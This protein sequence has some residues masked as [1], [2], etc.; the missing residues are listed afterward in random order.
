[1][2][3]D[4]LLE[5]GVEELP[6]RFVPSTVRQLK[7]AIEKE[8]EGGRLPFRAG[9]T[10]VFATPRRVAAIC[11]GL[12]D[13]QETVVREVTGPPARVAY[14][15][16][17][18]PT[19]AALGFAKSQGVDV[20]VLEVRDDYVRVEVT[21][22]GRQATEIL[23]D[24]LASALGSLSFPKTM[25]WGPDA[26]FGRPIRWIVAL[27][28]EE[29]LDLTYAG[30]SAGRETRGL[31]FWSR[32]PHEI[33]DPSEYVDVLERALVIPDVDARRGVIADALGRA[34][35][36]C[37]GRVVRDDELLEEVTF[38]VECP[39]VFA[40]RFDERFLELP[41]DVIVA[42]MKG[43]QRYFAVDSEEGTLLPR[44]LCVTNGPPDFVD[45]I[46]R[47]NERVLESRLDDAAFY[48]NED[49]KSPLEEKVERLRNVVWLEGLGTLFEKT[50]RIERLAQTIG[51]R[52]GSRETGHAV[53]AARLAKAD[54][55][56]EMVRDGKE[57]T[58]LQ[59][60]MGREYAARSNEP[61]PVAAA[62]YEHYLPRFA[63]DDL[64]SS[65]AGIIL[66]IADRIDSIVGCF[67]AGVVPTGSQDPYALRRQAIGLVRLIDEPGLSL[68]IG[69][70]V[71]SAAEGFG[72]GGDE[73]EKL[74]A[75]V[76]EF[77]RQRARN[78]FIDAGHSYDLVDAVLAASFDDLVGVRP[79]IE[80]LARFREAEDFAGLVIGARRVANIL[81]GQQ[82]PAVGAA[83]F[84]ESASVALD[85]A[86]TAAAGRVAAA[87]EGGDLDLAVRELLSL[88]RPIDTFFDEVMVMV[89]DEGL[90]NA[91][92]GLLGNVRDLF[93]TIADFSK[94][95]L[96]GEE[97]GE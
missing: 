62:I 97:A 42:A 68:S 93:L 57:F 28:G 36:E 78:V 95:V 34:A 69:D 31:R 64:P 45:D 63:G 5:I 18:A 86:R 39:T 46:R 23:P 67:S 72:V 90:R 2:A 6:A 12:A 26:R 4:L 37:G 65:P 91:R 74:S 1:M 54:L 71:R 40:G 85:E 43:H 49:T 15:E 38:L 19:K 84:V 9:E 44:F 83:A 47:G 75:D 27:L 59:G 96:E 30:V 41:R 77:V 13:R 33:R 35:V 73:A 60:I 81:K 48:W 79:R 89:D 56:T 92:L 88:R 52:L 61:G 17:G 11:E 32:G 16:D 66:G 58:E 80:A 10:R 20:S 7:D 55:V 51:D 53:R 21:D 3:R 22:E 25:R 8:L 82:A 50:E 29:I 14:G 24:L 87:I 94:V 76:L 70:L